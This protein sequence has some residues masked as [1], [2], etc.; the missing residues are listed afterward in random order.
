MFSVVIPYYKKRQ[1]IERCLDSVLNQTFKDYEIV[2]VDDG[3]ND[4]LKELIR[5]KYVD[6]VKIISQKNS[7]VS[8]ARN[9]GIANSSRQYIA[10]L[11]ADDCWSPFYLEKNAKIIEKEN[12]IQMIGS[13][14][15]NSLE[16]VEE[17]NLK[18][19][20]FQVDN[21]FKIGIR[22]TLFSSS[23]TIL[24]SNFFRDNKGFDPSLK[25]GED[26]DVWFRAVLEGGKIFFIKNTLVYYSVEDIFQATRKKANLA[27]TISGRAFDLYSNYLQRNDFSVFISKY[28]Y[29]NLAR[30]YYSTENNKIAKEILKKIPNKFFLAQ[31]YFY[32]PFTIGNFLFKKERIRKLAR[33]YMKFLFLKIYN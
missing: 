5:T 15:S 22:N 21:Y 7:G 23:T 33:K 4:G 9:T 11:D 26:L 18:L 10:F 25:Y 13:H 8:V 6:Q 29:V 31:L 30:S 19:Q 3:S 17:N 2:L 20:Y 14:Y 28:L 16:N 24:N 27:D 1:Y 32:I 12:S